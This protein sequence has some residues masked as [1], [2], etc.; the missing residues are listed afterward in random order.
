MVKAVNLSLVYDEL[1]NGE[2]TGMEYYMDFHKVTGKECDKANADW[3]MVEAL[4]SMLC[5]CIFA[6]QS[7]VFL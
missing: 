5:V 1:E 2:E 7:S 4:Q 6:I 3:V